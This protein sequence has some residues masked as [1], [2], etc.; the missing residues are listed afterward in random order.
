MWRAL[1]GEGRKKTAQS[2]SL[3]SYC[4]LGVDFQTL[5]PPAVVRWLGCSPKRK[6]AIHDCP[7]SLGCPISLPTDSMTANLYIA[8]LDELHGEPVAS[9][10]RFDP[11]ESRLTA[12]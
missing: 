2:Q 7:I 3:A 1:N 10:N 12:L 6:L 8:S 11:E 9:D 4:N 5:K